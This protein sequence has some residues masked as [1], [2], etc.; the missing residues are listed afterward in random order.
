[1]SVPVSASTPAVATAVARCIQRRCAIFIDLS[2]SLRVVSDGG[3]WEVD[4]VCHLTMTASSSDV[5]GKF[6]RRAEG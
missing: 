4:S 3:R 1:V 2:S 5:K 6:R